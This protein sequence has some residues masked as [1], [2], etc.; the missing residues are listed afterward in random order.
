M[1]ISLLESAKEAGLE[2]YGFVDYDV[3]GIENA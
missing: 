3:P 1:V 2:C